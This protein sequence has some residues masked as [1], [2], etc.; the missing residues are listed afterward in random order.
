MENQGVWEWGV[1]PNVDDPDVYDRENEPGQAW[2]RTGVRLSTFL[3][4]VA[5]FEAI[6]S[7]KHGASAP[8]LSRHRCQDI[9]APL[10]P[11]PHA[12]W[13]WPTSGTH[14]LAGDGILAIA[15]PAEHHESRVEASD[16]EVFLAARDHSAMEYLADLSDIEWEWRCTSE[17]SG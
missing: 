11:I 1:D 9:L 14:L 3:I 17:H 15:G 13:R 2:Q 10:K 5:V 8:G 7:A 12:A 4:H 16:W 6:W